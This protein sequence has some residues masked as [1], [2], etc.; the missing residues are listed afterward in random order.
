MCV[1]S[2]LDR[3]LF[4][5]LRV[6]VRETGQSARNTLVAVEEGFVFG[7]SGQRVVVVGHIA[8][9]VVEHFQIAIHLRGHY[10]GAVVRGQVEL[11]SI[12]AHQA[13]ISVEVV[14]VGQ[15][16][17]RTQFGH[18]VIVRVGVGTGYYSLEL[19]VILG[20]RTKVVL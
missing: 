14:E 8:D 3:A 12:G 7:A 9:E 4:A 1:E 2:V 5:G 15:E 19:L 13:L 10:L 16:T 18:V 11:V 6:E 17:I 20:R